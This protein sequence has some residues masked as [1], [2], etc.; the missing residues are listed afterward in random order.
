VGV[1]V[2]K[3]SMLQI[4]LLLL[5]MVL[6]ISMLVRAGGNLGAGLPVCLVGFVLAMAASAA[7]FRKLAA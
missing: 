5:G 2:R 4:F 6:V 3:I 1:E 7:N